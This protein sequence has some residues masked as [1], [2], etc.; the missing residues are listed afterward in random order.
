MRRGMPSTFIASSV[1]NTTATVVSASENTA[2]R[3]SHDVRKRANARQ[4]LRGLARC[5]VDDARPATVRARP[6]A[7]TF[8]SVSGNSH[9][10]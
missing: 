8:G 1:M 3:D 5:S 6:S 9:G 4:A 10:R 7:P 2:S